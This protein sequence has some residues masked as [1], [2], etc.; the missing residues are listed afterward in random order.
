MSGFSFDAVGQGGAAPAGRAREFAI[1]PSGH[2]GV[3][4]TPARAQNRARPRPLLGPLN[5]PDSPHPHPRHALQAPEPLASENGPTVGRRQWLARAVGWPWALLAGCAAPWPE[6]PAGPGSPSAL[7]RLQESAVAHGLAAWRQVQDLSIDLQRGPARGQG[8]AADTWQW[9][10][11]PAQGLLA[12]RNPVLA[13]QGWRRWA[14]ASNVGAAAQQATV[15]LWQAGQPVTDPAQ[16]Q[17]AAQQ[18]DLLRWLLLGPIALIDTRPAV[19]WAEPATLDGRRCDQLTL[20]AAASPGGT[21]GSRLALFI[22]RDQGLMRRLRVMSIAEQGQA[23]A[24]AATWDLPDPVLLHGQHWPRLCQRTGPVRLGGDTATWRLTGLDLNR[25]LQASDVQS[26][27][28]GAAATA[29][30]AALPG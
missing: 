20:D 19:N 24:R 29:P 12:W 17:A 15:Q 30:A 21:D 14:S 26:A 18:A 13:Q 27:P 7:A 25:R 6:V 8:A 11:L 10:C 2:A 22:D 3:N 9:R 1:A 23:G 16:L 28:M 5:P 4:S